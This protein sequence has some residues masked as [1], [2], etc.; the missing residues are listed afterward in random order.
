M[1]NITIGGS[2]VDAYQ[3]WDPKLTGSF[4]LGAYQTLT[5]SGA[6]YIVTPGGGSYPASGSIVD[7]IESGLAF[8]VQ[9]T[10]G[11]GTIQVTESSKTSGSNLRFRPSGILAESSRLITNLYAVSGTNTNLADGNLIL[12]DA[13]YNNGFDKNDVRKNSNSGENFGIAKNNTDLVVERRS[14]SSGGDTVF[15]SMSGLKRTSYKLEINPS[16]INDPSLTAFLEDKY[17]ATQTPVSLTAV[18]SYDFT[19]DANAASAASNRFR[20]VFRPTGTLPVSFTSI[21]AAQ[22]N[23]NIAVE[24]KVANQ[25]N[26]AG[27]EVEKSTNGRSFSK[28]ASQIASQVNAENITY[29]WLDENA[30]T[31]VNYYR[32]KAIETSGNAKYTEIVKVMVGKGGTGITVSPNP[33]CGSLVNIQFNNQQAGRYSIRLVNNAGQ[34]VY[35]NVLQH[36]GGSAS[37]SINMPSAIT[38]GIYQLQV[39]APDN[40]TQVQKLIIDLNN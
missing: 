12:F 9:A 16:N 30:V 17:K 27:Y 4:G 25:V 18:T 29:S 19:V 11:T 26:I 7:N 39:I 5:R 1:R 38:R 14:L 32:I 15:F 21:K 2:L 23:N 33:V 22:V 24:W 8:Y 36:A 35:K 37:Q 10:G 13:A 6:D 20:I 40:T 28:V 3:V 34:E 31:G